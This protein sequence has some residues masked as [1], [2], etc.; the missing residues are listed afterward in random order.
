MDQASKQYPG[1]KTLMPGSTRTMPVHV[2]T[3]HFAVLPM[4]T[5]AWRV[6]QDAMLSVKGARVW[7]TRD[8]SYVDY[9]LSPGDTLA[10]RPGERIWIGVE[11]DAE[12]EVIVTARY[13]GMQV[14]AGSVWAKWHDIFRRGVGLRMPARK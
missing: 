8:T 11:G 14:G 4:Q 7:L 5:L 10:L 6:R 1:S 12:A 9:W 2:V 13:E 3:S